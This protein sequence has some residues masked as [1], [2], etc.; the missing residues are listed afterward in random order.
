MIDVSHILDAVEVVRYSVD[1][2]GN[3]DVNVAGH[4]IY[5]DIL[6]DT[7]TRSVDSA[8]L[9]D[10]GGVN[11][12]YDPEDGLEIVDHDVNPEAISKLLWHAQKR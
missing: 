9:T 12:A 3:M 8:I 7:H 4:E 2:G 6:V 11:F 10:L 5:V 1:A